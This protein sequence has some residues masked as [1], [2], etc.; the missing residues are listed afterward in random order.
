MSGRIQ[1]QGDGKQT[2]FSFPF[3]LFRDSDMEAY[4]DGQRLKPEAF[5]VVAAG[6]E[7]WDWLTGKGP[8]RIDGGTVCFRTAPP[9]GVVVTLRRRVQMERTSNLP[10]SVPHAAALNAEL[11]RLAAG[12]Q[13]LADDVALAAAVPPTR[14]G[15]SGVTLPEPAP[16]RALMWNA[17]GSALVN[18][19]TD[20]DA[21]VAEVST[22]A[23]AAAKAEARAS[24]HAALS[25]RAAAAARDAQAA[26]NSAADVAVRQVSQA[27]DTAVAAA[28]GARA[29]VADAANPRKALLKLKLLNLW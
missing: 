22:Q 9:A 13:Q 21:V 25:A 7:G 4:V 28:D 17:D 20:L 16:R 1:Y 2:R 19:G 29:L 27:A 18:G 8:N 11:D 10:P 5:A 14:P 23:Q 3:T 15:A 24:D 26:I 6:S 12:L